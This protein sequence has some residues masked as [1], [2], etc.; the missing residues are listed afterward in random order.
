MPTNDFELTVPDLYLFYRCLKR[1]FH[2]TEF[3]P[4][5]RIQDLLT[6]SSKPYNGK[7]S[8]RVIGGSGKSADDIEN[9]SQE[10]IFRYNNKNASVRSLISVDH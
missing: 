5:F 3:M 8:L 10:E 6:G 1:V 4:R 9:F 7:Y 2:W